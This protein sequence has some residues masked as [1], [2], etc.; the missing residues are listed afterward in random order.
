[1][2]QVQF[3]TGERL[4]PEVGTIGGGIQPWGRVGH[5]GCETADAVGEPD[6]VF[7]EEFRLCPKNKEKKQ[8][9]LYEE[10]HVTSRCLKRSLDRCGM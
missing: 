4:C 1:M 9:G 8:Q 3:A 7:V 10:N 6:R 5:Q 2:L